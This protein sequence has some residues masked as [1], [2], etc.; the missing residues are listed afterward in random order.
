MQETRQQRRA[1]LRQVRQHGE[2]LIRRGFPHQPAPAD[3]YAASLVMAER[4]DAGDGVKSIAAFATAAHTLFEATAKAAPPA[5]ALACKKGCNWCCHS[6]VAATVPEILLAVSKAND[7]HR[8]TSARME[9]NSPCP[10]LRE[11]LCS[12]YVARPLMCRVANSLD[13]T[14]CRDEYEGINPDQDVPISRKPIDQ[15]VAVRASALAA[16]R[17][18]GLDSGIYELSSA[19]AECSGGAADIAARWLQGARAF[20]AA[21]TLPTD[22]FVTELADLLI[23]VHKGPAGH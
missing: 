12:I 6:T 17:M 8:Q 13:W 5:A 11:G 21:T 7:T 9:R 15:G 18:R 20:K 19:L 16:L 4:L 3:L 22:R 14:A 1:R 2:N 23:E 10:L